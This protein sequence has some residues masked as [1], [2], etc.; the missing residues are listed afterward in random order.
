MILIKFNAGDFY[1]KL[2]NHSS[3]YLDR[4]VLTTTLHKSMNSF[5]ELISN[6][7][8]KKWHKLIFSLLGYTKKKVAEM[9]FS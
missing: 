9:D 5:S 8:E 2:S 7:Y 6:T 3:F 1:V 4:T